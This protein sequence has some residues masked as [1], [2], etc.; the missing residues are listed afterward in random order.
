MPTGA[1]KTATASAILE[2]YDYYIH[3]GRH[4]ILVQSKNLL[5]QTASHLRHTNPSLYPVSIV[6]DSHKGY[7]GKVVVATVQSAA[8]SLDHVMRLCRQGF[9]TITIDE[10][11]HGIT[12]QHLLVVNTCIARNPNV[13][14]LGITATPFRFDERGLRELF[15]TVPAVVQAKYL[16]R[17]KL[18]ATPVYASVNTSDHQTLV[19]TWWKYAR[20]RK[21]LAF[22]D[23]I[24]EAWEIY[25]LFKRK[26]VEVGV[27]TGNTPY[28]MRL[29]QEE[30]SQ[31]IINCGVYTEGRDA[32]GIGCVLLFN[33]PWRERYIQMVGRGLRPDT[34]DCL[35]IGQRHYDVLAHVSKSGVL[36][37]ARPLTKIRARRPQWLV[38]LKVW[39]AHRRNAMS[40][41]VRTTNLG[42][43][44]QMSAK[45]AAE[46]PEALIEELN[47]LV[48]L[49]HKGTGLKPEVIVLRD[50]DVELIWPIIEGW[51]E[52]VG[53]RRIEDG[54]NRVPKMSIGMN[55]WLG[56]PK[57]VDAPSKRR[58]GNGKAKDKP[59]PEPE[60]ADEVDDT[61]QESEGDDG[62][63][64][65]FKEVWTPD[66]E[67]H[68]LFQF[69]KHPSDIYVYY[70]VDPDD[71]TALTDGDNPGNYYN[72]YIKGAYNGTKITLAEVDD[73]VSNLVTA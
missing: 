62:W 53:L 19:N 54:D 6:G 2:L 67:L 70:D 35:L 48:I 9:D 5:Y 40:E 45:K 46:N 50:E 23:Q 60:V 8:Y 72:S 59:E 7:H 4:L 71:I 32:P 57:P 55:V 51:C 1:G 28:S 38:R 43:G 18:L 36:G 56:V 73:F 14:I 27:V 25:R 10:C 63:H 24:W 12:A 3:G 30:H 68:L 65:R 31:V 49:T 20:G 47:K 33:K 16:H 11:H 26:G 17:K 66:D 41:N 21:T 15:K 13:R 34:K 29:W 22:C 37:V 52:A 64:V 69:A 39:L 58:N 44:W 42:R 61:W